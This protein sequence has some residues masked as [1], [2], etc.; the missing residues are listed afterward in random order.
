MD[1]TWILTP[2]EGGWEWEW[3]VSCFSGWSGRG[4]GTSGLVGVIAGWMDGGIW[5]HRQGVDFPMI[6]KITRKMRDAMESPAWFGCIYREIGLLLQ[7]WFGECVMR[8]GT[9]ELGD[10]VVEEG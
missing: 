9:A 4:C 1:G 6:G 8:G 10:L 5:T 2:D 7:L 3:E